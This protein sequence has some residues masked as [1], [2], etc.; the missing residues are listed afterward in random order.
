[1]AKLVDAEYA[2]DYERL[3]LDHWWWQARSEFVVNLIDSLELPAGASILDIGCG[4]GWSFDA[5]NRY[6]TVHGVELDP[7]L[8]ARAGDHR[9]RI[10]TGPFDRTYRPERRF[11]LIVMLDVLEH[12]EKPDEAL[13]Y[14][15]ELLEPGGRI[16]IT[17]PSMPSVW[18]S[19][20]D[21]NHHFVRYTRRSFRALAE[22]TGFQIEQ[23]DY[24]F[25]WTTFVKLMFRLKEACIRTA[26]RSPTI[27]SPKVNAFFREFS[28]AEQR[29]LG[30]WKIPFGTSLVC[31]GH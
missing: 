6:G 24:F 22:S 4:G 18:T 23:L 15:M 17:V 2:A 10:H 7:L 9:S 13:G 28:I 3:A 31:L 19:H 8:V 30:K 16:L 1:M 5:W 14:A 25:H 11:S 27:P 26:P 21:L 12:L 20:D 29:F